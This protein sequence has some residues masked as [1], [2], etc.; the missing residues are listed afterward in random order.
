[1]CR[2]MNVNSS[3]RMW[4]PSMSASVI[5]MSFAVAALGGVFQ[6]APGRDAD[7]LENRRDLFVV[8]HL[9]ELRL[10]DVEDLPAQGQD[11]LGVRI[12]ARVGRAAG[13]VAFD[14]VQL[15]RTSDRGVRQSRS[16]SGRP[17]EVSAPLRRTISRAFRAA[18]RASAARSRLLA[19]SLAT[20]GFSSKNLV[21]PS[22]TIDVTIPSTSL[23]PSFVLVCP[24]NCG[25]ERR[26][27][28][29]AVSPSRKSSPCGSVVLEEIFAF[30]P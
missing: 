17:P 19:M 18:S 10:F 9:D 24:S 16:F 30:L 22:L 3:V 7:G 27:E 28:M 21:R 14:Q 6:L 15:A 4:L 26:T 13:R 23:L 5:S 8:E 29:T 11:G 2:K 20:L 1:M 12:A 25:S